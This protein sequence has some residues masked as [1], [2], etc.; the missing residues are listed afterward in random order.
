MNRVAPLVLTVAVAVLGA[1][2]A[3]AQRL[4]SMTTEKFGRICTSGK[5]AALCD[6][7]LSGVADAGALAHLNDKAAGSADAPAAFCVPSGTT[8]AA[9]RAKVVGWLKDHKAVWS[10]PVGESVVAALHDAYPCS[11]GGHL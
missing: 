9:M 4:S 3:K 2:A 1:N 7:Y 5:G 6:A 8:T 11:G 10:K